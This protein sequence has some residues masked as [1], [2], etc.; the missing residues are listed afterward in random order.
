MRVGYRPKWTI[1][2]ASLQKKNVIL[3]AWT[4]DIPFFQYIQQIILLL[5]SDYQ[6]HTMSNK[7]LI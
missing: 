6:S 7:R 5:N 4:A 2:K 1:A 3:A